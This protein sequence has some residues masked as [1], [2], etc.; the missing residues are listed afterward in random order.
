[1]GPRIVLPRVLKGQ[2]IWSMKYILMLSLELQKLEIKNKTE[3]GSWHDLL[4]FSMLSP[5][6]LPTDHIS[7]Q[8]GNFQHQQC[9]WPD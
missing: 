6:M 9:C 1:M 3:K 8:A 2:D 4:E 7:E 5:A